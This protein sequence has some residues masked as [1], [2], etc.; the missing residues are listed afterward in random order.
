MRHLFLPLLAGLALLCMS[1]QST[2]V[3]TAYEDI[4]YTED[5]RGQKILFSETKKELKGEP[6]RTFHTYYIT[7][8]LTRETSEEK[9]TVI[10]DTDFKFISYSFFLKPFIIAGASVV[11]LGKCLFISTGMFLFVLFDYDPEWEKPLFDFDEEKEKMIEAREANKI[12]HYPE[13]HK[14]FTK[15]HIIVEKTISKTTSYKTK[16]EKTVVISY[17]KYEYDNTIFVSREIGKDY[18]ST[19]YVV[20]HVG[21]IITTPIAIT[22]GITGFLIRRFFGGN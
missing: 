3:Y 22:S 5:S 17:E 7:E 21:N 9:V 4:I 12:E 20:N 6:V 14:F 2:K 15:N 1:C 11:S 18:Y 16:N 10:S 13:L 19:I 8:N